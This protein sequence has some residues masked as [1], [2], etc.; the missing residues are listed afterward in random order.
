M[1]NRTSFQL[2][3]PDFESI[4]GRIFPSSTPPPRTPPPPPSCDF[5]ASVPPSPHHQTTIRHI[6]I[7]A[8]TLVYSSAMGT[9]DS[10]FAPPRVKVDS[11]FSASKGLHAEQAG[12]SKMVKEAPKLATR[13]GARRSTLAQARPSW[14]K[15]QSL[16]TLRRSEW[17]PWC[18]YPDQSESIKI[19]EAARS[20][21]FR[22][23]TNRLVIS[24]GPKHRSWRVCF[25]LFQRPVF[26]SNGIGIHV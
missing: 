18:V 10:A 15:K 23:K 24:H 3:L 4:R 5:V 17:I 13:G 22:R 19:L 16:V 2:F 8:Y 26:G 9:E 14:R 6:D 20:L 1:S 21:L 7:R 25:F 11:V 12:F